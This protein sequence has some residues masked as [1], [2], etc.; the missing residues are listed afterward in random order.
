MGLQTTITANHN[1]SILIMKTGTNFQLW[2]T[3]KKN[4]CEK[5]IETFQSTLALI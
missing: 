2:Q 3:V 4:T 1:P 5:M